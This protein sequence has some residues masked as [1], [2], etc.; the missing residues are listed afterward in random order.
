MNYHIGRLVLSSFC[1]G[2]LAAAGIWWCSFCRM[3]H[4]CASA[5]KTNT[6]KYQPQQK[7]QHKTNW[8]QDDRCGN[9]STQSQ[10][11]EDGYTVL[12]SETCWAHNKWHKIACDI[13]LVFH[14]STIA[15]MHGPI[16]ISYFSSLQ[17]LSVTS[18][19]LRRTERDITINAHRSSCKAP[20]IFVRF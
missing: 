2:V 18:L 10:A 5:C 15:M 9:S 13:K 3:K 17:L 14:S 20:V 1:V 7:P 12:M 4:N 8:E 11:L 19:T 16:N 6:T